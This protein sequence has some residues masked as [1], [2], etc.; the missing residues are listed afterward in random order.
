[1]KNF[2]R[3]KRQEH[4]MSTEISRKARRMDRLKTA[5]T[6]P[7][8]VLLQLNSMLQKS[9]FSRKFYQE[10]NDK[11]LSLTAT[12]DK[13]LYFIC[14]FTLMISSVLNN[15]PRIKKFLLELRYTLIQV[16]RRF[17]IQALGTDPSL[18]SNKTLARI[19]QTSRPT[20]EEPKSAEP[21]S[22]LAVHLKAISSY[23]ADIRIFNRLTDSIKYM[24]WII[25]EYRSFRDP[26][27]SGPRSDRFVNFLQSLNCL[28]LELLENAGWLTEHNWVDTLDNN[29]WSLFTYIWCCRVWGVYLLLEILELF[30]RVPMKSWDRKWKI[31]MIK[32]V[33]QVPLVV[34]WSLYD[35]CLTPF[36]VGLCGSLASWWNFKDMWASINLK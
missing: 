18:S 11:V 23:L 30:R 36:W 13:N 3:S 28:V 33:L 9:I 17:V 20:E 4:K 15:K 16:F 35:G 8:S 5:K 14:Y 2:D 10:I 27:N 22:R 31:E 7:L 25:D 26:G 12:V 1:M 21:P 19:F 34:H 6:I 24:P 29:Y 32:Q